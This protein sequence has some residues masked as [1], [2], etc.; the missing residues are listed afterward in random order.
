MMGLILFSLALNLVKNLM[1][2]VLQRGR[3]GFFILLFPGKA[4]FKLTKKSMPSQAG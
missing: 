4:F 2:T 1:D 3:I